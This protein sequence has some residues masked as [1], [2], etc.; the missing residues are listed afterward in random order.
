MKNNLLRFHEYTIRIVYSKYNDNLLY[1]FV[2]FLNL[3]EIRYYFND[4]GM[5]ENQNQTKTYSYRKSK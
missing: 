3:S 4:R 1:I 5:I 2:V